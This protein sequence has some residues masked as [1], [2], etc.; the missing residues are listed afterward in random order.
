M[1]DG[2]V[3]RKKRCAKWNEEKQYEVGSIFEPCWK[4]DYLFNPTSNKVFRGMR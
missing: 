1:Q 4:C 3:S 2:L